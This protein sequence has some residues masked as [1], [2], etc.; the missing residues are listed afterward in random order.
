MSDY[1]D[2]HLENLDSEALPPEAETQEL[3]DDEMEDDIPIP[4]KV[5]I[6]NVED[7]EDEEEDEDDEEDDEE[8]DEDDNA[9]GRKSRKRNKASHYHFTTSL[10][11]R[12]NAQIL[13]AA[14][15]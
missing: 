12:S 7:D 15:S 3:V 11:C 9:P 14:P 5:S 4:K 2:D 1:D 8:E 10:E 6:R 13:R